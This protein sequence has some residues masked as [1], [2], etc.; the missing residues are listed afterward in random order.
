M[1]RLERMEVEGSS[2]IMELPINEQSVVGNGVSK[3]MGPQLS[4]TTPTLHTE[5]LRFNPYHLHVDAGKD[6]CPKLQKVTASQH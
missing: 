2:V 4:S 5:D 1:Q 6:P 3:G